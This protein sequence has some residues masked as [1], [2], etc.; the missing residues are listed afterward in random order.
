MF[1]F[2][3]KKEVLDLTK[4]KKGSVAVD[5]VPVPTDIKSQIEAT[6]TENP[7]KQTTPVATPSPTVSTTSVPTVS[8][9]EAKDEPKVSNE[10][11][12]DSQP[13]ATAKTGF[14]SFFRKTALPTPSSDSE[15]RV[16]ALSE[17]LTK[18]E[19]RLDLVEKKVDS[20]AR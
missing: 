17:K 12:T 2:L 20:G 5:D 1:D 19:Q 3:K 18:V 14:S 16:S 7:V 6:V 9:N 15:A 10:K 8:I 11:S 4:Q 13:S